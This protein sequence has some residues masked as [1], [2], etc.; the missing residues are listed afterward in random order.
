MVPAWK[1]TIVGGLRIYV[2][3]EQ[4]RYAVLKEAY[5]SGGHQ[6]NRIPMVLRQKPTSLMS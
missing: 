4:Q 6:I 3:S 1:L 5:L 2:D